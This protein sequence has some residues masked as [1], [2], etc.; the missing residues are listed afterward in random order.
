MN[1][2]VINGASRGIGLEIAK[3]LDGEGLDELWLICGKNT[4]SYEFKTSTRFFYTDLCEKSPYNE[5]CLALSNQSPCIKYLVCSAGIGYNGSIDDISLEN[6]ENTVIVNCSSLST[7]TKIATSFMKEGSKIIHIASGA[8]FLPQPYFATYSASKTYVI[9]FS[10]AIGR[11]LA[12]RKISVTAVCPG[13]V[14]TDFFANLE[15]VA[16]YKKKHL[17]GAKKVACGAIK[18]SKKNKRIYCPTISMKL[19]HL[20]SKLLPIN[21]ILKFYK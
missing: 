7:L 2:A 19:V 12:K 18:A 1:I 15:N 10:R 21:L 11:E 3:L 4:P 16:E 9:H 17:I 8:G 5:I 20:A 14:D 13:P 6:I